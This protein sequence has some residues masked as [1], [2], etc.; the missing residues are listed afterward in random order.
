MNIINHRP[1]CDGGSGSSLW[2]FSCHFALFSRCTDILLEMF[3]LNEF[4]HQVLQILKLFG[5]MPMF[6]M[7][8]ALPFLVVPKRINF[9]WLYLFELWEFLYEWEKPFIRDSQISEPKRLLL[10]PILSLASLLGL[11]V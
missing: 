7:I 3:Q 8:G 2:C 6:L 11:V 1:R 10:P 4:L 9:D 5:G